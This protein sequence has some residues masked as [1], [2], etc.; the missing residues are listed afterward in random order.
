[1][2]HGNMNVKFLLIT[3]FIMGT[4]FFIY[5]FFFN[6]DPLFGNTSRAYK[7]GLVYN[8]ISA[9]IDYKNFKCPTINE[10]CILS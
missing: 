5:A 7:K 3:L 2:M 1:M 6:L 4:E 8:N 10:I 9:I